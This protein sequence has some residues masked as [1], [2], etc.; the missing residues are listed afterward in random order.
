MDTRSQCHTVPS[1]HIGHRLLL[2]PPPVDR[3]TVRG[4]CHYCLVEDC[5]LRFHESGSAARLP[6]SF[7][8]R[9]RRFAR[10]IQPVSISSEHHFGQPLIFLVGSNPGLPASIPSNQ[11]HQMGLHRQTNGRSL[12]SK[13][14]YV[15]CQRAIRSARP[16]KL[17][18]RNRL[19]QSHL[20]PRKTHE[21]LHNQPSNLASR[22]FRALPI[23]PQCPSR[24]DEVRRQRI[25]YR[26]VEQPQCGRILANLE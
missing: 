25:L 23:I 3:D 4:T 18:R 14:I 7:E 6:S 1:H 21:A 15:D 2:H 16:P 20:H 26:L 5:F 12:R 22:L 10:N 24:S 17:P 9:G 13:R 11:E 8:P 19:P